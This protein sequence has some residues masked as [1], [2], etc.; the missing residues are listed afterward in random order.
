MSTCILNNKTYL[1]KCIYMHQSRSEMCTWLI[2]HYMVSEMYSV[3][4]TWF[5]PSNESNPLSISCASLNILLQHYHEIV[6]WHD[7]T[8]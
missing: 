1:L 4:E 7:D 6:V 5:M 8:K 3:N 2:I